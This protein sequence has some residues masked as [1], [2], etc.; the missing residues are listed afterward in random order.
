MT[1]PAARRSVRDADVA[2]RRV[3]VRVDFNVPLVDG[4]VGDDTRIRAALPTIRDLL[5][6][7]ATV[8]LVSHLGRPKGH[9]DPRFALDPVARRLAVLLGRPAPLAPGV[10]GPEVT[11]AVDRLT[12]GSVLL[13]ENV[14]FEPGE[15]CNDPAF[16]A[17]LA[18]LADLYV[19]DAFGAAHRANASTV[20]VAERLPAY[21]GFLL[22]REAAILSRVL[23][24]PERP[25]LAILGGAKISDKLAVI[26][27][28]LDRVDGLL[29]GGGMANTFLLALG[30]PI[31]R[32]LA[33]P[34]RTDDARALLE[35]ARAGGVTIDLPVDLVIARSLDDAAGRIVAAD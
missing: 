23:A 15:E 18:D 13:L 34:D 22:E 33:E 26:G 28:L 16:A 14:R 35:R 10:V 17:A 19:D 29:L 27:N 25:F 7:G 1:E 21:A 9:V 2:G 24:A 12:P 3:L 8:I 5:D 4:E 32:S 30:R 6:R 11:A 31:G 20:G